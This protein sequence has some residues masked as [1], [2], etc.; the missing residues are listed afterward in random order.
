MRLAALV[1]SAFLAFTA[2]ASAQPFDTP[3]ALLEAFYQPYFDDEFYDDETVFRSAALNALYEADAENTPAG[4]MGAI[5]FDPYIAAQDYELADLEIGEPVID[6]D[7]ATVD[8]TFDNM[9]YPTAITYDLVREDGGWK[10][11]DVSGTTGE[12]PYR[13]SEIF[14][15]AQSLQ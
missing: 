10:I 12:Y 1:S 14:L 4:E 11:D 3:Q 2:A 15:E 6:G 7:A 13:L 9:S 8:V 5:E